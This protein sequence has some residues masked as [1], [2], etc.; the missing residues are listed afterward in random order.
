MFD[1]NVTEQM[2]PPKF[3]KAEDMASLTYLNEA[4]VLHNLRQRYYSSLIYVSAALCMHFFAFVKCFNYHNDQSVSPISI[5]V[6]N[7][8]T[9]ISG[10]IDSCYM[11]ITCI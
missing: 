1:V 9:K 8:L 2:N 3:E 7:Q 10:K 4:T 6:Y 5:H 11:Q